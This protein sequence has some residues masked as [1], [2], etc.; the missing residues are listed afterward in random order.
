MNP[1]HAGRLMVILT[2]AGCQI[3][4]GGAG[5]VALH[6]TAQEIGTMN[7]TLFVPRSSQAASSSDSVPPI[8]TLAEKAV[9]DPT[10]FQ[11]SEEV[12]TSAK[13]EPE[14]DL[15][16]RIRASNAR[17]IELIDRK[18]AKYTEK[19][20]DKFAAKKKKTLVEFQSTSHSVKSLQCARRK[21]GAHIHS[22]TSSSASHDQSTCAGS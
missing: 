19:F 22:G 2:L 5:S 10:L 14:H 16:E 12:N 7:A 11:W 4:Q 3:V 9:D 13:S 21:R 20:A 1:G 17:K 15:L 18:C 6:V 8:E